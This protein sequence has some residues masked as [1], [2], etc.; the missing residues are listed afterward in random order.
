M[1]AMHQPDFTRT[2]PAL[3]RLAA[4]HV[5]QAARSNRATAHAVRSLTAWG[6][7]AA[8]ALLTACTPTSEPTTHTASTPAANTGGDLL[9]WAD[10]G[11]QPVLARATAEFEA[12]SQRKV[13]VQYGDSAQMRQ[14][15]QGPAGAAVQVYVGLAVPLA[16]S[17]VLVVHPG[18]VQPQQLGI[19]EA[20]A[21]AGT[22]GGGATTSAQAPAKTGG[23][24][25]GATGTTGASGVGADA[26]PPSGPA[27]WGRA[28][29]LWQDQVCSLSRVPVQP[30][31]V[32]GQWQRKGV[33]LA[34]NFA[35][36]RSAASG[37]SA[38]P[39]EP[40]A[41]V[42]VTAEGLQP[43]L[44]D[45]LLGKLRQWHG[46]SSNKD[47]LH[48]VQHNLAHMAIAPCAQARALNSPRDGL[49]LTQ[50]SPALRI[51]LRYGL[52]VRSQASDAARQFAQH[53]QSAST[54]ATAVQWGMA[55]LA[56]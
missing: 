53:L 6:A 27:S 16:D 10:A 49:T 34:A 29:W 44:R 23:K 39:V 37:A 8:A 7:C 12:R 38:M 46:Q 24:A 14:Q 48:A 50:L 9:V 45:Q 3:A 4:A 26:A 51:E 17:D 35:G 40:V 36:G 54:Q 25:S 42:L 15:L 21:K 41:R 47:A 52:A 1:P 30:G 56:P 20:G 22:P 55:A 28:Q 32:M 19:G 11:L 18:D 33:V 43:G 5:A 2:H 31:T 13:S